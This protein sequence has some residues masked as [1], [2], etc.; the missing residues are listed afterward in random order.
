MTARSV[1]QL[2]LIGALA[3][4]AWTWKN[5]L[6]ENKLDPEPVS[7][8]VA[9]FYIRQGEIVAVG[10]NKRVQEQN[11][12]LHGEM[13][14]TKGGSEALPSTVEMLLCRTKLKSRKNKSQNHKSMKK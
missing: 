3:A 6:E 1:L 5:S 11:P 12:I 4:G 13:V 9:G 7:A 2:A 10:R 8:D 14:R